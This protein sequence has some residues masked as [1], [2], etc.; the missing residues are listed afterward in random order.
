MIQSMTT[1]EEQKRRD[2]QRLRPIDDAFFELLAMEPGVCEEILQTVLEDRTITV[3]DIVVQSSKRNLYGRSV[4]LDALCTLGSGKKV[5]IEVQ[6]A[7]HD[8]HLRRARFNA[9]SITVKD[10]EPGERFADLTDLYIVYISEKDF[11]GRH[12]TVYHMDKVWRETGATADDGLYELFVNAGVDDGTR[13]SELMKCFMAE[14]VH[15]PAFPQISKAVHRLKET[16]GGIKIMNEVLE[17]YYIEGKEEGREEGKAEGRAEGRAEGKAEGR[18]EGKA[19]GRAEGR[20]EGKAVGRQEGQ[21]KL[22]RLLIQMNAAGETADIQTL[23]VD[24]EELERL[25]RKYGI[26]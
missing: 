4:R 3:Q 6:R 7:D 24:Q 11:I 5:N 10:S 18:A 14:E 23:S 9:S 21:Q 19:E 22:F 25:Y 12:K 13:V 2:I 8:D 1:R 20:A 17:K 16:E 15:H 26:E